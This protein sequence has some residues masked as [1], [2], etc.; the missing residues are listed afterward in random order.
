MTRLPLHTIESASAG[1]RPILEQLSRRSLE[2]GKLLNLHAQLAHAPA[3]LA[4]YMG[5]RNALDEHGTLTPMARSAITLAVA[6]LHDAT[7]TQALN[8]LLAKRAGWTDA[9]VAAIRT[10]RPCGDDQVDAL[11][12][13]AREAGSA[14][15]RVQ[16]MTWNAALNAG[17]TS[18]QLAEAFVFISIATFVASFVN[19]AETPLDVPTDAR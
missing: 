1:T 10:G 17:W 13:V 6:G 4:A 16:A 5:F 8:S 2:T 7:Y 18:S 15:G 9:Q 11:L 3:A 14:A 19:Y 12:A